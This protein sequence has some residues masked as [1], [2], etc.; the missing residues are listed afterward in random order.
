MTSLAWSIYLELCIHALYERTKN[1]NEHD[2]ENSS[3]SR[4]TVFLICP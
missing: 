2:D 3:D 1:H 4:D